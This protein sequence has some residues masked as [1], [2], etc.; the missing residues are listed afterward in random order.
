[1]KFKSKFLFNDE[2]ILNAFVTFF[3]SKQKKSGYMKR[4]DKL[5]KRYNVLAKT[6]NDSAEDLCNVNFTEF[7]LEL[8]I[9][10]MKL[11]MSSGPDLICAEFIHHTKKRQE[12]RF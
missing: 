7:E 8:A 5:A 3:A 2:Q 6:V 10:L 12:R 1:M 4:R 11:G 9:S